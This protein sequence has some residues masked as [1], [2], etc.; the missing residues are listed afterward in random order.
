MSD[1]SGMRMGPAARRY[2]RWSL[3]STLLARRARTSIQPR[4]HDAVASSEKQPARRVA[5]LDRVGEAI[6]DLRIGHGGMVGA[7]GGGEFTREVGTAG[8]VRPSAQPAPRLGTFDAVSASR[9]SCQ[10]RRRNDLD[11]V[12]AHGVV[13]QAQ[14]RSPFQPAWEARQAAAHGMRSGRSSIVGP[15]PI[16]GWSYLLRERRPSGCVRA[17]PSRRGAAADRGAVYSS[18]GLRWEMGYR[19]IVLEVPRPTS[20]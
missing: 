1:V 3:P 15:W 2:T 20:R 16:R 13:D 7:H 9:H 5:R 4:C 11:D 14:Q 18:T 10:S 12:V 17:G 8:I 19:E 6:L